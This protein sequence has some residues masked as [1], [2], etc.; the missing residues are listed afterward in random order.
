MKLLQKV[1]YDACDDCCIRITSNLDRISHRVILI[2][3]IFFN[4]TLSWIEQNWLNLSISFKFHRLGH[5]KCKRNEKLN[6]FPDIKPATNRT[7]TLNMNFFLY[8]NILIGSLT[9]QRCVQGTVC[10]QHIHARSVCMCVCYCSSLKLACERRQWEWQKRF[11]YCVGDIVDT[12][13]R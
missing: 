7:L 8:I 5:S 12:Y 6:Q 3:T 2:L 4:G 10:R 13:N 11:T 9:T 1:E